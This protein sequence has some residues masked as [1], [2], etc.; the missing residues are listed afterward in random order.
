MIANRQ[1]N[2]A[3]K[4]KTTAI[5]A[6]VGGLNDKNSIADMPP[7]DALQMENWFPSTNSVVTRGG[8]TVHCDGLSGVGKS[9]MPYNGPSSTALFSAS[10]TNFYDVS[11]D[12]PVIVTQIQVTNPVFD[13]CNFGGADG[14]FLVVVNGSDLPAFYN[15]S[16][17]AVSGSGFSTPITGVDPTDFTQVSA[18]K[19]RLFFVEKNS[20]R[21]W[22]LGVFAIGGEAHQLDF[23]GVAKLGGKLVAT[24]TVSSSAGLTIDDYF[25]A[26]TSEGE[27]LVYRGTDPDTDGAFGLVGNYRIGRPIANGSA[28]DGG[29]FLCKFGADMVAIT[30]DGF[31]TLQGALNSDVVAKH[32][33]IND[34]I[35]N[36]VTEAVTSYRDNFGWQILLAPMN[37]KLLINVPTEE[38]NTSYQ[39]V[40]N[41]VTGA[42]TVFT[43]W[44]ASCF[45][46]WNDELYCIEGSTVYKCDVP[47]INDHA[48]DINIGDPIYCKVKTSFQYFGGRGSQ[49]SFKFVRPLLYASGPMTPL[50]G[51]NVDLSDADITGTVQLS[52]TGTSLWGIAEWGIGLWSGGQLTLKNWISVNGIGYSAA[53]KMEIATNQQY[54][55]WQGWEIMYEKGGIL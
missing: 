55:T 44:D 53:L 52:N 2:R 7:G 35:I 12:P 32:L 15:G 43:G 26:I 20:L 49:K 54:S 14:N 19:N 11:S 3:T 5:V 29:R 46:Y 17:W 24:A 33:T 31:T 28:K 34:K 36:T 48:S 50:V 6:P 25:V 9:L 23:S 51:I 30:A 40:M 16:S 41:T 39:Y 8:S 4:S 42:W 38:D 10:G 47:G 27:C 21:C 13:H 37:N 18:W 22:Y 1:I 45:A